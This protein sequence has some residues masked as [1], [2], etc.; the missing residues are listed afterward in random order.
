M[1]EHLAHRPAPQHSSCLHH[2]NQRAA[3]LS[4]TTALPPMLWGL[5]ESL[6]PTTLI[7]VQAPV[8]L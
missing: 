4:A 8:T 7:G 5:Q 1:L 2:V 3:S 6:P